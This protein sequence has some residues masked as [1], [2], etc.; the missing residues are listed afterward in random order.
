MQAHTQGLEHDGKHSW[1]RFNVQQTQRQLV[2]QKI[3]RDSSM[4]DE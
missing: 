4:N 1:C 2:Q 3:M